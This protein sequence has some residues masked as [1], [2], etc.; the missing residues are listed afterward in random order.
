MGEIPARWF[1]NSAVGRTETRGARTKREREVRYIYI[2]VYMYIGERSS[3]W[4]KFAKGLD[5]CETRIYTRAFCARARVF[6]I[7]RGR[8]REREREGERRENWSG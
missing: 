7:R 4:L 3:C 6:F 2:Y 1:G 5:A 8:G